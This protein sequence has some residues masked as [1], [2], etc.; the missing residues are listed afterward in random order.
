M[1]DE[2]RLRENLQRLLRDTEVAIRERISDEPSI[3]AQLT[4]RHAAAVQAGR[5]DGSPA[6][7]NSFADESITQSAVHWL[8]GCVFVRFLEDNGWLDER[9]KVVAWLA[10]QGERLAIAKDH[11]TLFLRPDPSLTDRDYLLQVFGRVGKLP[12]M[13]GLFDPRHNPLFQLGPTAQ[14]AAKIVEFFQNVD[15]DTNALIH[16]FS[17]PEHRTRFLGDLY[18]NLSEFARDKYAL[19]QT[20]E[21]VLNFILDRTLTPALDALGLDQIRLIDPTCGSGHFLLATFSRLFR[22]WQRREPATNS[23]AL[24]QRSLDA[25]FG[26]DLN[27]FAVAITR[28]RLLIAALEACGVTSL[29]DALDFRI[30]VAAG[31]SL[32]HGTRPRDLG[33]VQRGLHHDR[34]QFFYET[35]DA[36]EVKQILSQ[37]YHV[38]VGNPPYINVSDPV[39]RE[40]YRARFS[41]CH[42]K[43]QLGVPFTERF[44]DLTLHSADPKTNPA[45]WIGMIV[46]N[47]FMKRSF[48]KKLI[49]NYLRQK[50]LTYIVDTSGV[51]LPG[52]GTPTAI[53]IGRNQLPVGRTVRAVLGI[54]GE[55]GVPEI[56]ARQPVWL[57]IL[58]QVESPGSE[59][60]WVSVTDAPRGW[61]ENHPWS[62]GGGGAVELKETIEANCKNALGNLS[63]EIGVMGFPGERDVYQFEGKRGVV[64][65]GIDTFA[66]VLDGEHLKDWMQT[67]TTSSIWPYDEHLK[68]I[69]IEAHPSLLRHLWT[70]KKLLILRKRFGTP[71]LLLG[72]K[73][74]EWHEL[75]ESKFSTPVSIAVPIVST[76]NHFVFDRTGIIFNGTSL[77]I[78]FNETTAANRQIGAQG[79]LNSSVA[80]FWLKQV[81]FPK[82][83]DTV[84][85]DGARVRK[86]LWDIYYSFDAVALRRFPLPEHDPSVIVGV[87]HKEADAR[88]S[89]LP[90]KICEAGVPTRTVLSTARDKAATHLA[91][92]IALQEEL[93]W[94]CYKLYGLID[95]D[96]TSPMDHVQ[97]LDLG[98]RA[99]E[100]RM[101]RQI[102]AGELETTWFE[103]H[104]SPPITDFPSHWSAAYR[105]VCARRLEVMQENR[106]IGLIEQ[107]EYKRRWNLPT[108]EEMEQAALK[109]WLL[110]R[111][112]ANTVWQ[113]HALVSCGQLRDALARDTDWVSVTAIFRGSPVENLDDLVTG[114][115][116]SEAVPFL[117][118]LRYTETGLRKRKE[119]ERVWELQRKDDAGETVEIPVP[120]KYRTNDLR[121]SDYWRLRGGLDVPKERFIL[122]PGLERDGDSSRVLGWAG[123][124]YL[125]QAQALAG[126]YQRMRTEEGW[127]PER[128]KPILA[129]LLDLKPWLLQ[130]HNEL[131]PE[132]GVKLGEY[133]VKFAESQCQELGFS[134]EEVR[135]WR[136]AST[137]RPNRRT[138]R[139]RRSQ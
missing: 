50:D 65:R 99:F 9:N 88:N 3:E 77:V 37:R 100:I 111:M 83:G 80:C 20:P 19:V 101:A 6:G 8:L 59:S 38:V 102:Q 139:P 71:I 113:E 44:F 48:G 73:W 106:D 119:W 122:Y 7:Y 49:E 92:M 22:L 116:V 24:A 60:T 125:E 57:A 96:L 98:Q 75:Y 78:K 15:P 94:Q 61:F 69:S 127:E 4:E 53:I 74:Y 132:S 34:L 87:I 109:N 103:R 123:W 124:N 91:R 54:R 62:I 56:P 11:R 12:G 76:H 117:P 112:E 45:G 107:P 13:G 85:Q 105:Q 33:G 36:E 84:G 28:F 32:L 121:K 21:F 39:L 67:G 17:D 26:V 5:T 27:P 93:D 51:Y 40:A 66:S 120:P 79:L 118:V 128:L 136:P 46:S 130:W 25:V 16:D 52:Y 1:I 72:M 133:F 135:A 68:P 108:W 47:A 10:G 89:L 42:G 70:F 131:D 126:Y 95:E 35:E 55:T 137:A 63:S 134:P 81:C 43:Y 104:R 97:P 64:R 29:R 18:E 14:G 129:G 90:Q 41:T 30:H 31:D 86:T 115:T 2:E 114:L 82:G 23:P 138:Q 110:D 58:E